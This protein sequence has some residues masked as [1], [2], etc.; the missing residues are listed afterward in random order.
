[1]KKPRDLVAGPLGTEVRLRNQRFLNALV[2]ANTWWCRA[3]R[4]CVGVVVLGDAVGA[5]EAT[6]LDLSS[7]RRHR[8]IGD[9]GV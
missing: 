8:E 4:R 2:P 6:G 3:A 1:M 5:A 9:E 7:V